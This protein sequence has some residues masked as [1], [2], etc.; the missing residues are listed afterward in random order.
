MTLENILRRPHLKRIVSSTVLIYTV[1]IAIAVYTL[2]S[3]RV[4]LFQFF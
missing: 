1:L 3:A 4:S 2:F